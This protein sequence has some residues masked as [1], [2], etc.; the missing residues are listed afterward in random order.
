MS[1]AR[2]RQIEIIKQRL[3]RQSKPRLQVS[4][5]LLITGFAGFLTSF[6]L[7]HVGVTRMWVRYPVVILIS[8]VVFLLMLRIWLWFRGRSLDLDLDPPTP[9]LIVPD[10][11]TFDEGV[12]FSG[13]DAGGGG[14]GGSWAESTSSSTS[15]SSGDS[16]GSEVF[17]VDFE[18]GCLILIAIVALIA[19]ALACFYVIYIAPALLAE[20]LVDGV[21]VAGLYR[22]VRNIEQRHWLLA[23]VR[24]TLAPAM[25]AAVFFAF[26]GWGLQK[27]VPEAHT[28]GQVWKHVTR[29]DE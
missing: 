28:I 24:R 18:E 7:L 26:A 21:L 16:S 12:G 2:D 23:A 27:A 22:R 17:A 15:V 13:G 14:A 3:L 20:I 9:D 5:L 4:L 1:Q 11:G 25:L 6:L 19:G 8:Y 29:I 10:V